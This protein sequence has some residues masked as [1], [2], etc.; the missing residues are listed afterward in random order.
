LKQSTY[1][2][3]FL[4]DPSMA[5]QWEAVESEIGRIMQRA[6]AEMI[7]IKKWDER[8]LAYEIK[9]RKRGCYALTY[10]KAPHDSISGIERDARLSEMILRALV[11]RCRLTDE[12]LAAFGREA[13]EQA[14]LLR[15]EVAASKAGQPEPESAEEGVAAGESESEADASPENDVGVEGEEVSRAEAKALWGEGDEASEKP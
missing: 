9:H 3:M 11:L 4:F 12:Q 2:A 5:T 15:S 7:G 13:A 1:E 14:A 10:F 8:R 6:H